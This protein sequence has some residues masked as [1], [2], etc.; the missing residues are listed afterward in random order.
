MQVLKTPNIMIN[1]SIQARFKTYPSQNSHQHNF[2]LII[3]HAIV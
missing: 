3:L 1:T 2:K